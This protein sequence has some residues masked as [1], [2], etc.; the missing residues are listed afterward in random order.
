M[1]EKSRISRR[2]FM[3]QVGAGLLTMVARVTWA[4]TPQVPT[5]PLGK[6]GVEVPI[7]GAGM[8]FDTS[9]SHI[10]L[11]QAIKLGVTFWDTAPSYMNGNSEKGIGRFFSKFPAERQKVF[12]VTKS[13]KHSGG[14]REG[15]LQASLSRL[16]TS[17]ID[18]YLINELN[19]PTALEDKALRGWV[20][21]AKARGLIRF[22]GFST[23]NAEPCLKKA[24]ATGW[25]DAVLFRYN[26]RVFDDQALSKAIDACREAGIGLVTMK[27]RGLGPVNSEPYYSR[28]LQIAG[29]KQVPDDITKIKAVWQDQRISCVLVKMMDVATLRAFAEAAMMPELSSEEKRV[30][31]DL[32]KITHS[33]YCIG[34]G[35][36]C[37][38]FARVPVADV[39]R[40]LMYYRG[41]GEFEKSRKLFASLPPETRFLMLSGDFSDAERVC[42]RRL[43]I[44]RLMAEAVRELA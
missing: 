22:F 21:N 23:H 29:T 16:C 39:M 6:T 35:H 43:P 12:L 20:E 1:S 26:Y 25:V 33:D 14:E 32:A 44:G 5:R 15:C 11:S 3:A 24:A 17:Y 2:H 13:D 38:P 27:F 4:K 18:L 8:D 10:V 37:E 28:L 42:P 36:L 34:C 41:Y 31:V 7:L 40:F 19:D 9:Y 30:L